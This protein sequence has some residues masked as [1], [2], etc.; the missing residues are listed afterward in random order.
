MGMVTEKSWEE[1]KET[2]LLWFIN[3]TLQMFGWAIVFE[4]EDEKLTRAYP[5]RC[6]FR[7]FSEDVTSEGYFKVTKYLHDNIK[8][9][10]REAS[11]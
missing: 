2:G 9:L 7:G 5:A 10:V 11:E 1:F 3:T 6:K 4:Y 8:D